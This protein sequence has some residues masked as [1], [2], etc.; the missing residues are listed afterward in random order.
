[1]LIVVVGALAGWMAGPVAAVLA[2]AAVVV[3][4]R[5]R[6]RSAERRRMSELRSAAV[7]AVSAV[8]AELRAGRTPAEALAA[9]AAPGVVGDGLSG[10]ARAVQLGADP[11][12]AL[13]RHVAGVPGLSRLAACWRVALRTGVGL[14]DIAD[15]LAE[16]LRAAARRDDEV[17]VAVAAPRATVRLLAGLPLVGVLLGS[18]IGANPLHFLLHTPAGAAVLTVGLLLDVAGL[19]WTQRMIDRVR[20]A[21]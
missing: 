9:A 7:E 13:D 10:A 12:A 15:T 6:R 4:A 3:V 2:G 14:A 20:G 19:I 17:A 16:D 11:A 18:S 21:T 5:A 8:A 1:M